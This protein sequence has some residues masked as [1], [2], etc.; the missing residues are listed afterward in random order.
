MRSI[1]VDT[2]DTVIVAL[3]HEMLSASVEMTKNK[4]ADS[5]EDFDSDESIY[6]LNEFM[7]E[8]DKNYCGKLN[9]L[10]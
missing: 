10:Y 6:E 4:T 1:Q 7:G 2:T 3:T 9:E 5:C 8:S